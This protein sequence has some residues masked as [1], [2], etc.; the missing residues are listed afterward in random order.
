[1]QLADYDKPFDYNK[2]DT[3]VKNSD[4]LIEDDK[5]EI[6]FSE[7]NGGNIRGTIGG[8]AAKNQEDNPTDAYTENIA[9]LATDRKFTETE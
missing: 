2:D 5:I 6:D 8:P 3:P 9:N 1:M 7:G 4:H